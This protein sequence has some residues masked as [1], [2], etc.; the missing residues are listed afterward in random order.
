M[1]TTASSPHH[2]MMITA[3]GNLV[4]GLVF[5]GL[6]CFVTPISAQTSAVKSEK[7]L[8]QKREL[9]QKAYTLVDE[10]AVGAHGLKLP[11]NRSFVLPPAAD[12]PRPEDVERV[13]GHRDRRGRAARHASPH[14]D[15][16]QRDRLPA[17]R[18]V[19]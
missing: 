4:R 1:R 18:G 7:E 19:P 6:V 10:I 11:E 14:A 9:T 3:P 8:Q 13:H 2:D 12:L 5:L 17:L 16:A 15:G